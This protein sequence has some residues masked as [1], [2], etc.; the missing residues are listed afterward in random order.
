MSTPMSFGKQMDAQIEMHS[1]N[2]P[3][4]DEKRVVRK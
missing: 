3:R 2:I 4:A 1:E